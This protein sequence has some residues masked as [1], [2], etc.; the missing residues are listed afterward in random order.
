[1]RRRIISISKIECTH[2]ARLEW[3]T[4]TFEFKIRLYYLHAKEIQILR[5]RGVI[6]GIEAIH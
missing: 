3:Y 2:I 6:L 5:V 4:C 1:M